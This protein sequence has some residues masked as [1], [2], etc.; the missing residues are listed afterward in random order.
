MTKA[1]NVSGVHLPKGEQVWLLYG[2]AG[3]YP[4]HWGGEA[5]EFD[6]RRPRNHQHLAFS[7]GPPLCAGIPLAELQARAVLRALASCCSH[8]TP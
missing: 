3:R 2:S 7:R 5:D 1:A 8:L 6:I 4:R